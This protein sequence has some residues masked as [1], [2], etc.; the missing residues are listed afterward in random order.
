MGGASVHK[1]S[2]IVAK[3]RSEVEKITSGFD[4]LLLDSDILEVRRR[5]GRCLY[6][7]GK[8]YGFCPLQDDPMV[9]KIMQIKTPEYLELESRAEKGVEYIK[10]LDDVTEKGK[11]WKILWEI[12]EE[13][14]KLMGI[15]Y[16][17]HHL[18]ESMK[19]HPEVHSL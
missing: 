13:Q 1:A 2:T 11:A 12:F 7:F 4:Y 8:E 10:S 6:H 14:D 17:P 16:Y 5:L 3:M 18:V 9:K 15:S 19:K